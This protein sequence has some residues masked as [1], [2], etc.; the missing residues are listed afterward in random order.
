MLKTVLDSRDHIISGR[1]K[2][3]SWAHEDHKCQTDY[4][5]KR[6]CQRRAGKMRFD[7]SLG[8]SWNYRKSKANGETRG[9]KAGLFWNGCER[10]EDK[11]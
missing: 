9:Q 1:L 5:E 2:L 4:K 11:G 6:K 7:S 8:T 3:G 10:Q